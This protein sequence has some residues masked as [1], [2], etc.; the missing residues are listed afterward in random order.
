M[1]VVLDASALLAWLLDEPGNETVDESLHASAMSTVNWSE[2]IQKVESHDIDSADLRVDIE[3][4]GLKLIPFSAQ[5]AEIT[6]RFWT[7]TR[8]H[9]LSL[10]DHAC[11]SLAQTLEM[12]VLTTDRRWTELRLPLKI[13]VIR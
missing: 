7:H 3:A 4:I 11:L 13:Q 8:R 6:G 2:V 12:P 9:G 1:K 5:Q 10:G